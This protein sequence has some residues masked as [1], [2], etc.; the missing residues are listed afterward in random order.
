MSRP[1]FS[2]D[3]ATVYIGMDVNDSVP[4][5]YTYLYAIDARPSVH[6]SLSTPHRK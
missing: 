1:R 2:Q 5:P 6:P 4:V 3:G